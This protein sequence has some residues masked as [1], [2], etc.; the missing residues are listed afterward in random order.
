MNPYVGIQRKTI[1]L[2]TISV[3][4]ILMSDA[5]KFFSL[6]HK[7]VGSNFLTVPYEISF[8]D[9]NNHFTTRTPVWFDQSQPQSLAFWIILYL[10]ISLWVHYDTYVKGL[11]RQA[12]DCKPSSLIYIKKEGQYFDIKNELGSFWES[13]SKSDP[14]II[15]DLWQE[16]FKR[17]Q[18]RTASSVSDLHG[19]LTGAAS[20]L[21]LREYE[22]LIKSQEPSKFIQEVCMVSMQHIS[23]DNLFLLNQIFV[24]IIREKKASGYLSLVQSQQQAKNKKK[25][26]KKKQKQLLKK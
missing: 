7:I 14:S 6:M 20:H 13:Y 22:V 25:K 16:I 19:G 5:S 9:I 15:R 8:D 24:D 10:E 26:D 12:H 17:C 18:Q 1:G 4:P 23:N 11:Y 2:N 3:S 21:F